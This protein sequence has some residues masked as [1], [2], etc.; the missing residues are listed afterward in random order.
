[1]AM[2]CE[3]VVEMFNVLVPMAT[4]SWPLVFAPRAPEPTAKLEETTPAPFPMTIPL[5]VT[6]SRSPYMVQFRVPD[7]R[8]SAVPALLRTR[9]P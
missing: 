1:M 5:R 8:D 9:N 6:T 7:A 3:A 4:L 2:F